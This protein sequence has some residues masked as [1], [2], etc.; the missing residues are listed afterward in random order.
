MNDQVLDNQIKLAL[1]EAAAAVPVRDRLSEFAD[2]AVC[3]LN[4]RNGF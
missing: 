4:G 1:T 2:T 3:G